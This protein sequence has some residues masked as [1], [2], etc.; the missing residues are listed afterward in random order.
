MK[1]F[2]ISLI[3][4]SAM[5]IINTNA[6]AIHPLPVPVLSMQ[7]NTVGHIYV[8]FSTYYH[9][10]TIQLGPMDVY[11]VNLTNHN[12]LKL[13]DLSVIP[14]QTSITLDSNSTIIDYTVT[15]ENDL[16]TYQERYSKSYC[17]MFPLVIG[18]NSSQIEDETLDKFV[19]SNASDN[20]PVSLTDTVFVGSKV[21]D[22]LPG[23]TS[24]AIMP[25]TASFDKDAYFPGDFITVQGHTYT[26]DTKVTVEL[27]KDHK[28]IVKSVDVPITENGTFI[29]NLTIP[30]DSVKTWSVVIVSSNGGTLTLDPNFEPFPLKQFQSGIVTKD[31]IC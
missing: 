2:Y 12:P 10:Q 1:F 18:L 19:L 4:L 25:I 26:N 5:F 23:T 22:R 13:N 20:C 16:K 15:A 6:Y 8:K 14:N 29:S 24:S 27:E 7:S 31:V 30:K 28:L 21:I 9:N 11:D 17:H 3:I